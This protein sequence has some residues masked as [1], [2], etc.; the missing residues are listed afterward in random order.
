MGVSFEFYDTF[1]EQIDFA[2]ESQKKGKKRT[3]EKRARIKEDKKIKFQSFDVEKLK[4]HLKKELKM[5]EATESKNL[6]NK[7]QNQILS[8]IFSLYFKVLKTVKLRAFFYDAI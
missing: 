6:S 8:L 2:M 5:A 4:S 7:L 3:K 1:Q